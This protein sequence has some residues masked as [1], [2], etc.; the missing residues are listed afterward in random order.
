MISGGVVSTTVITTVSVSSWMPSDTVRVTT[1][2]PSGNCP[3]G[4]AEV[5]SSNTTP[6]AD[7]EYD[8]VSPSS[9]LDPVPSSCTGVVV[10]EVH[11]TSG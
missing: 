1:V 5:E 2:E 11:S 10:E 3:V 8:S 9:S 4:V 6:G 7:Q